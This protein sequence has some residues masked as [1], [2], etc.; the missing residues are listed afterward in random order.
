MRGLSQLKCKYYAHE[1]HIMYTAPK[2]SIHPGTDFCVGG[3]Q[4][5]ALR[6]TTFYSKL[7]APPK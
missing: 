6:A 7:T 4:T 2:M 3:G 1:V 5:I